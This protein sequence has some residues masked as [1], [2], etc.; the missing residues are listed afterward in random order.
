MKKG[1]MLISAIFFLVFILTAT[2]FVIAADENII[3]SDP[4]GDV[5]VYDLLDVDYNFTTTDKVPNIDIKGLTYIHNEGTK[6]VTLILQVYGE[7]EDRGSLDESNMGEIFDT[8]AYAMSLTTTKNSYLI[9]YVNNLH[10]Q[11][12]I[13]RNGIGV[14]YATS[15]DS[16]F[17]RNL[18]CK[19][20]TNESMAGIYYKRCYSTNAVDK[21]WKVPY[22]FVRE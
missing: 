3:I 6:R 1:N 13:F 21:S 17:C 14:F 20:I 22:G 12:V 16:V 10:M 18:L 9:N 11:N 5:L 19:T 15:T 7:I 2:N 8:V 4:K